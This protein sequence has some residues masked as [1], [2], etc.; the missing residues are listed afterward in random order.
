[1]ECPCK[2]CLVKPMCSKD[3]KNVKKYIDNS[4]YIISVIS[5]FSASIL[6]I[7]LIFLLG[8]LNGPSLNRDLVIIVWLILGIIGIILNLKNGEKIK[9]P[10]IFMFGPLVTLNFIFIYLF[11]FCYK[12]NLRD[13]R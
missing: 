12:K 11:S 10:F 8:G 7:T 13:R 5:I 3:C 4:I 9:E 1:M 6:Y 2:N